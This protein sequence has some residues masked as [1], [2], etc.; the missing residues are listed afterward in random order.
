MTVLASL[1]FGGSRWLLPVVVGWCA[2]LVALGWSYRTAPRSIRAACFLLKALGL[3]ALGLCLLE[4]MWTGQRARPGANIY[5][6]IADNSQGLGI[7]DPGSD[8]SRGEVLKEWL[9]PGKAPWQARLEGD[10]EVRRYLFDARLQNARSFGELDFEGKSS[11]IGGALR[12]VAER[13]KGRPLAGILLFTDGN[14]TDIHGTVPVIPGLPPV[15]PVVVG[16]QKPTRDLALQQVTA[17]QTVFEDAPVTVQGEIQATGFTGA[18]IAARLYDQAG[19]LVV[20]QKLTGRASSEVTPFRAQLKPERP[21]VSFYR[22]QVAGVSPPG[23]PPPVEAT[24]ANN[25][26][27]LAVDRGH[28]PYRILYVAGRPN[29]EFKFLNRAVAEDP[30]LQMVGL[31]RVAKREP[32]FDF[33]G[34]GGETSNPLFRGFG[35]QGRETT[36]RYDQPVLTRINTRDE[37]E[38]QGGF[39]KT[40][41]E[42]YAYH[43]IILD[44]VEADFFRPEQMALLPKFVSERGGSVLMLGGMESFQQGGYQRTPAGDML[45][46]YLDRTDDVK[47]VGGW[48]FQLSREGWLQPWARLR[49]NEGEEHGR[50]EAMPAFGVLNRVRQIK[51]GASVV[52]T[53]TDDSGQ[54]QPALVVQRFGRGHTAALTVGDIWRWGM[55]NAAAHADMDKSWR[56][57]MRWLVADVPNRVELTTEPQPDDPNGAMKLQVRVRDQGFQPLDNATVSLEIRTVMTTNLLA[58]TN[59]LHL[60]AEA[61]GNEPGVYEAVFVPRV[62][63]GYHVLASVTNSVGAEV[64]RAEAGWSTD[65]AAEEFRSLVPNVRLLEDLARQTGGEIVSATGLEAFVKALPTRAAPVMEPWSRPLWNTP[66]LFAFALVMFLAEWGLRRWKGLA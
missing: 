7:R 1:F 3:I 47:P 26:R 45:P 39:P 18:P 41:E 24:E 23:T 55:Q 64:G 10:F 66:I 54:V 9:D 17:S 58:G 16:S 46:V 35:D 50:L 65:L 5:A 31:I 19:K 40:A 13:F 53:V 8:R 48:K 56:Q 38:L 30:Q 43:A 22:M 37:Q 12:T 63:A 52:A 60:I 6:I 11:A 29:W 32:K 61:A 14:A 33:R 62:A 36:E 21:G 42:L 49:D 57:L 44:D 59:S 20:E 34:R 51:P 15:F 27:V 28:G 4:P 25:S 2:L